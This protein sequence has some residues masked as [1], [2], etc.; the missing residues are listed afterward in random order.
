[1]TQ[2]R[3]GR[4]RGTGTGAPPGGAKGVHAGT[5]LNLMTGMHSTSI[6][7]RKGLLLQ[8]GGFINTVVDTSC[9]YVFE[10]TKR[11]DSSVAHRGSYLSVS[12]LTCIASR[13]HTRNAGSH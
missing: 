10:R 6:Y 11:C 3:L 8:R 12:F 4:E 13:K 7:T 5:D 2:Q 1:M 9:V